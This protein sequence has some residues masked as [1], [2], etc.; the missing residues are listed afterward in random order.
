MA[1][2]CLGID[3]W[4]LARTAEEIDTLRNGYTCKDVQLYKSADDS[5][6]DI[7]T[8]AGFGGA[9]KLALSVGSN[10]LQ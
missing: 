8:F 5:E 2:F 6:L 1:R 3:C 4:T 7:E 10:V 9:W